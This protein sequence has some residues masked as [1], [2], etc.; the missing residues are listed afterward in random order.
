MLLYN[1]LSKTFQLYFK[2]FVEKEKFLTGKIKSRKN[3]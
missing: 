2:Y 1:I 3:S